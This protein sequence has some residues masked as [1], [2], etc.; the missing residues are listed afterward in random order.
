MHRHVEISHLPLEPIET[1]R[2]KYEQAH[3]EDR[4]ARLRQ[5]LSLPLTKMIR[6]T[7]EGRNVRVVCTMCEH[8]NPLISNN[9]FDKDDWASR[10]FRFR[11]WDHYCAMKGLTPE[12][13]TLPPKATSR[14]QNP[15]QIGERLNSANSLD[16]LSLDWIKVEDMT[17]D[18]PIYEDMEVKVLLE[19]SSQ[20]H[21][22]DNAIPGSSWFAA[23]LSFR[24][25]LS[26]VSA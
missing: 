14:T 18:E 10:H 2:A 24:R 12:L 16:T 19:G 17:S 20:T 25:G 9:E 13:G 8:A 21:T 4:E 26:L 23:L 22:V 7:R 11:H 3:Q 5:I 1:L 6:H 15:E